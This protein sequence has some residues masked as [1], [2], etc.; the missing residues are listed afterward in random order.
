MEVVNVLSWVSIVG[1]GVEVL[2]L[3]NCLAHETV[4]ISNHVELT[5]LDMHIFS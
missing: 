1:Q 4:K 2:T 5:L 3:A